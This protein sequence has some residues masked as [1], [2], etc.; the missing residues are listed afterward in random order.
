MIIVTILL[1]YSITAQFD[2]GDPSYEW[3]VLFLVRLS[4]IPC[5]FLVMEQLSDTRKR[6]A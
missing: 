2:E 3:I 1:E 4:F 5:M 6:V